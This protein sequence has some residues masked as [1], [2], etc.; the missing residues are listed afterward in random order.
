[1]CYSNHLDTLVRHNNSLYLG[2]ATRGFCLVN[3]P[4][5]IFKRN[6]AEI[7]V[8]I[9]FS[10]YH[11][12]LLLS[13]VG[14]PF[15]VST[16]WGYWTFVTEDFDSMITMS[17]SNYYWCTYLFN[18]NIGQWNNKKWL[19][20]NWVSNI[21]FTASLCKTVLPPADHVGQA[22]VPGWWLFLFTVSWHWKPE[23][24]ES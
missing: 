15:G 1:M 18:T 7:I 2:K 8:I 12:R 16:W 21:F 17:F 5:K 6:Y 23:V 24:T 14:T 13:L 3:F 20:I 22:L 4:G 9:S 11:S 10:Y 19:W